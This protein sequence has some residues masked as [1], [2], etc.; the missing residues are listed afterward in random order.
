MMS[1]TRW[2][3][4]LM[5]KLKI[6]SFP[7]R[8]TKKYSLRTTKK[9]LRNETFFLWIPDV[10]TAQPTI[11]YSF[12]TRKLAVKLPYKI[13]C[14]ASGINFATDFKDTNFLFL[15]KKK[16]KYPAAFISSPLNKRDEIWLKLKFYANAFP[17]EGGGHRFSNVAKAK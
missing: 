16:K 13:Y 10:C 8:K 9:I 5:T 1:F 12:T 2:N 17:R 7:I 3:F 6:H 14:I 4:Y 11:P 15:I